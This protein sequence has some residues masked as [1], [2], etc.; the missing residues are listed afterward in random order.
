MIIIKAAAL[1][2][3]LA[4]GAGF[5]LGVIRSVWVVPKVGVRTAEL[6]ESPIMLAVTFFA[7]GWVCSRLVVPGNASARLSMGVLAL[8]LLVMAE[9]MVVF[10]FRRLSFRQYLAI[11]DPVSGSVY[12]GLLVIF[13]LMPMLV[14]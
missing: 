7:A 1:Y 14:G 5:V 6:V 11:R 13:A 3:A 4:F 12:I 8:A 9:L 10:Q 2:F